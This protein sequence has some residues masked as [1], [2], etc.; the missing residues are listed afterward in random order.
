MF[1]ETAID[2]RDAKKYLQDSRVE[3]KKKEM[4]NAAREAAAMASSLIDKVSMSSGGSEEEILEQ[5]QERPTQ[6]EFQVDEFG[7]FHAVNIQ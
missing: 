7:D 5:I 2:L 3:L 4:L 6:L 1:D